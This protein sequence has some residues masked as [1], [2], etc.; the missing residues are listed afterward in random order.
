L[1]LR[2]VSERGDI[3]L[4]ESPCFFGTLEIVESL[5]LRVVELATDPQEGID[6]IELESALKRFDRVA[7]CLLVTNCSNPL[8]YILSS[9]TKQNL[10]Q[11][12]LRYEV[13]LIEDDIFGDLHRP[14]SERPRVAKS[15]DQDEGVILVGSFSKTLAPGLRVGWIVPG[16][17]RDRVLQL[18]SAI[19][20][21]TPSLPQLA[22]TEFLKFGSFD[23]HLRRLRGFLAEQVYRFSSAI[24]ENFPPLTRISRPG[25]GFV[26]WIELESDFDALDLA[27][28]ALNQYQ[29]AIVP[30][31]LFSA[32][33]ERYRNCFRVSCGHAFSPRFA[34]AIE[35][36]G[37]LATRKR[38]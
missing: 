20:L 8:G 14:E 23:A 38:K 26:L 35:L 10:V 22:V 4:V 19:S 25:G 9:K 34:N 21:A 24:A 31:N 1:A 11:L 7:A 6:L 36:L 12:L 16:K 2:A 17:F 13:P 27:A 32:G 29:I 3:V 18:K 15:F 5:G 33:G 30:G 37:K 28:T